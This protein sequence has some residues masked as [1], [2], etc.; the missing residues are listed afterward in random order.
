MKA[1]V[2]EVAWLE[3]KPAIGPAP[4]HAAALAQLDRL[5]RREL[6]QT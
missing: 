5:I 2:I 6:A 3:P 4:V 1:V